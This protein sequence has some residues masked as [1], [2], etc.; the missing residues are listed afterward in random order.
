MKRT[1]LAALIAAMSLAGQAQALG[2]SPVNAVY[3]PNDKP[4]MLMLLNQK[5][6]VQ[7]VQITAYEVQ[8]VNGKVERIPTDKLRFTPSVVSIDPQSEQTVRYVRKGDL[9]KEAVFV[10]EVKELPP[11]PSESKSMFNLEQMV[12]VNLHW[13][14]R[15]EGAAPQLAVTRNDQGVFITNSG[16]ATAQLANLS[17]GPDVT[18][19]GLV[20]YLYPGAT[21]Q[22]KPV[23]ADQIHVLVNAQPQ[24]LDIR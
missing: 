3:G 21:L 14:W 6:R 24:V 15:P 4:E 23:K 19:K 13:I 18:I 20:G 8:V 10:V 9:S 17:A 11:P 7:D 1:I 5:D 2:I 12:K 16:S 22:M